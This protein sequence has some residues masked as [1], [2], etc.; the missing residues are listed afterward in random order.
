MDTDT[1]DMQGIT[2]RCSICKVEVRDDQAIQ[3]VP[4]RLRI[5]LK[6]NKHTI[7]KVSSG[8]FVQIA[9]VSG[10][11]RGGAL[12]APAPP[13]ALGRSFI[14]CNISLA[15]IVSYIATL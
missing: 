6:S 12:G 7:Q 8:G 10:V 2:Y 15:H 13:F 9:A 4:L 11:A 3:L 1:E 14:L 5:R